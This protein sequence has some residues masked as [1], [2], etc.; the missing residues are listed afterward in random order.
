MNNAYIFEFKV[1]DSMEEKTLEETV[2]VALNQISE[3]NYD[4]GLLARGIKKEK[5]RHYG[6]AF[7]GKN[8]LIGK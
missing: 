8:V 6:F 7:C 4:A 1:Q 5:I 2:A 3:K